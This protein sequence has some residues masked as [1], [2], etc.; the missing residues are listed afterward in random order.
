MLQKYGTF[1]HPNSSTWHWKPLKGNRR[2][3]ALLFVVR[4]SGLNNANGGS[5]IQL[6]RHGPILLTYSYR[7][8]FALRCFHEQEQEEAM[9]AYQTR[10]LGYINSEA[11]E[12]QLQRHRY[13]DGLHNSQPLDLGVKDIHG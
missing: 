1:R 7:I 11:M 2:P 8:H 3:E 9:V 5:A 4:D 12:R 13:I 6:I 10:I